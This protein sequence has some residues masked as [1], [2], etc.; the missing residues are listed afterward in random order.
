MAIRNEQFPLYG[1]YKR[2]SRLQP[3]IGTE[4][5]HKIHKCTSSID[6]T[7]TKVSE[8]SNIPKSFNRARRKPT[9]R[10][11]RLL[12]Q[13]T[14][15]SMHQRNAHGHKIGHSKDSIQMGINTPDMYLKLTMIKP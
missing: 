6:T 11:C 9:S 7:L 14:P 8:N 4:I 10:K 13:T 2:M 3:R 5:H 1:P 12:S 15:A